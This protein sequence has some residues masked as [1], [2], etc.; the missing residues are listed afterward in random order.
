M[1]EV[2]IK[3]SRLSRFGENCFDDT[4]MRDLLPRDTYKK[5][6]AVI[7][8]NE[9]MD[10]NLATTVAHAMKEWAINKG[11]THFCHWFQPLT[12]LTAEKHDAFLEIETDGYVIERFRAS[13]LIQGEPDASSFPSGGTR[14]TFE[15]RGYTA[16]DPTSPAFIMES[17]KGGV[18][19]IPSVFISYNGEALDKKTPLLRSMKAIND[20]ALK[21][22]KLFGNTT[23]TS[24]VST[25]GAEQEYFLIDKNYY[26]KRLDLQLTGRTLFGAMPTKAQQLDDHYFGSIKDRILAYMDDAEIELDKLG[27]PSKT[28]HNEV[29]PN[30][31]EIAPIFNETN[32][33]ADR[34]QITMDIMAKVANRHGLAM[35][36]HE[37]PFAGINGSGK[38]NNWSLMDSEGNNLLDPGETP[39]ENMQFLVFLV[40][41]L[42]AVY[43][44]GGLLRATAASA[45]NDHRLGGHEAPPAIMSVFLGETLNRVLD[46][47][48]KGKTIESNGETF[49]NLGVDKL[50][51]IIK[52]NTDRNRTSP[53]AFTGSKFEFRA[54]GS[55]QSVSFPNI[56][57]NATVS[58]SLDKIYEE[59]SSQMNAGKNLGEAVQTVLQ[60]YIKETEVVRFEGNNYSDEWKTEAAN[61]GLPILPNTGYALDAIVSLKNKKMFLRKEIYTEVELDLF[62]TAMMEKYISD[63]EIELATF[64]NLTNT[65]ILPA[66]QKQIKEL[67]G[68]VKDLR[69]IPDLVDSDF[70]K[71]FETDLN[72]ILESMK[73]IKESVAEIHTKLKESREIESLPTRTKFYP[74]KI[75]GIMAAAREK[76]DELE[77]MMPDE[78]WPLPKYSKMLFNL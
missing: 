11:A 8:S 49:L 54:V 40:A 57:L 36:L 72:K 29:A 26:D 7:S 63:L 77:E 44:H 5:M 22:L 30:Q 42:N 3:K 12:G 59:I 67:I 50:P 61:R 28:R 23:A 46:A 68:M 66:L 51:P 31:F 69:S 14:S 13:Q 60:K 35:L 78:I 4:V 34:N 18:L 1:S 39:H 74:D 41:V 47:I 43:E 2:L 53:F 25:I 9:K 10:A 65:M 20:S 33:G 32:I 15:A 55:R 48:K 27:I 19:C 58:D 52:H 16:W 56:V 45:G 73:F 24:V 71:P 38:H 21:I 64:N 6:K 37:K 76:I 75:L 17:K 70:S 62:H